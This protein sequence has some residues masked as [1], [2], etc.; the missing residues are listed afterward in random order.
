MAYVIFLGLCVIW[1]TSFILMKKA[2]LLLGPMSVAGWR[3]LGGGLVLG[4]MWLL[5]R[6]RW[7]LR[8]RHLD[9]LV[10]LSV[11]GY[12]LPF[13]IQPWIIKRHG[14][15][16]MGLLISLVPL[17][18]IVVSM[19]MLRVFPKPRQILG[20]VGGLLFTL[21]LFADGL[22]K[23]IPANHLLLALLVPLAYA[24]GNTY[25]K[26][27][28]HDQPP[29][30]LAAAALL[31]S[32]VLVL[33]LGIAY[34]PVN[35]LEAPEL[36]LALGSILILGI[37]CTGLAAHLFYGLIQEHG[38]LFAGM[39]A[40]LVPA[41]AL[42]WGWADGETI[43]PAQVVA[44]VGIFAMVAVVQVGS[45]RPVSVTADAPVSVDMPEPADEATANPSDIE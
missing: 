37:L 18:T 21:L 8:R 14:S 41:G 3:L 34:E 17:L 31:V 36:R 2:L 40:Y 26:R 12:V 4:V 20:V 15:A 44:L 33:P 6:R 45:A 42:I 29:L 23:S 13:V 11:V 1:G 39:V 9:G 32:A 22:R 19:P 5:A 24:Y 43:R 27:R 35:A 30:F 28:F 16:F 38:P 25:V 7:S 10:L